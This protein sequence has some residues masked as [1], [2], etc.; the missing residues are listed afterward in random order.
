MEVKK[1]LSAT[2]MVIMAKRQTS[3][4]HLKLKFSTAVAVALSAR[5]FIRVKKMEKKL[6]TAEI[7]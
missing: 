2:Y 5:E 7:S 3:R 4:S 6:Q 1:R